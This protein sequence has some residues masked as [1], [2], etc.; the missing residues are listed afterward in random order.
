[1]LVTKIMINT[2]NITINYAVRLQ[3]FLRGRYTLAPSVRMVN[4]ISD[5]FPTKSL[6]RTAIY[7][8]ATLIVCPR[9]LGVVT[10]GTVRFY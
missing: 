9:E 2:I 5:L 3:E 10:S 6:I 7:C 8:R 4:S 1:M